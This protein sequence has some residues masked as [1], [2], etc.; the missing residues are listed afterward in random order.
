MSPPFFCPRGAIAV[1][2]MTG[3]RCDRVQSVVWLPRPDRAYSLRASLT[4]SCPLRTHRL[5]MMRT[6]WS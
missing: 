5:G 2:R 3:F 4:A 1:D 6:H